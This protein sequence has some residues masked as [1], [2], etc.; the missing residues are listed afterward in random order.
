MPKIADL[1]TPG[2]HR[3]TGPQVCPPLEFS[4][5]TV[6]VFDEV[7]EGTVIDTRYIAKG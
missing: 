5:A 3:P 4:R 7:P 6:I 2:L 1:I